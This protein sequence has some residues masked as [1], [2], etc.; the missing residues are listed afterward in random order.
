MSRQGNFLGGKGPGGHVR[1]E[2][3]LVGELSGGKLSGR[4]CSGGNLPRTVSAVS[5]WC[6]RMAVWPADQTTY[7]QQDTLQ[8]AINS[9]LEFDV[10]MPSHMKQAI[11]LRSMTFTFNI[12]YNM[13]RDICCFL[14]MM[15]KLKNK[16]YVKLISLD[17]VFNYGSLP[18]Q[19][20]SNP[21]PQPWL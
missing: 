14:T 19:E 21:D 13:S 2:T 5:T 18:R 4:T 9:W 8:Y 1:R 17:E 12:P 3:V 20:V 15:V 7:G 16:S 11:L 6:T 10:I